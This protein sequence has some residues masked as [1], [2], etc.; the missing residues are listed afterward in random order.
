MSETKSKFNAVVFPGQGA[1]KLGMAKDFIE[2]YPVAAKVFETANEVLP[3]DIYEVCH[4]NADMLNQTNY[5]QPAILVAEMAMYESLKSEYGLNPKAYAG[6][7]LGEYSALTA[8][9]VISFETAL[10]MVTKRGELMN[11]AASDG[12]MT[13]IIMDEI[14]YAEVTRIAN[15]H[16][17]DVAND[18]SQQQVV[19]SGLESDM[20]NAITAL[21][22]HYNDVAFRAVPLTVSSA[23]HSRWMQSVEQVY[24]EYLQPFK[25]DMNVTNLPQ[26]ASNFL[27][28]FY[29][30]DKEQLVTAL[31]KQISGSVKW[32]SNMALLQSM[33]ILEL[34]PNRPLRGFFKTI[35]VDITSVIN[36]KSAAKAFS[37]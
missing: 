15:Q 27:G 23:F 28:G 14:P 18:N 31:A 8:A 29:P 6:H 35:G 30:A 2:Q 4:E 21:T 13:A 25:A 3:F 32:R 9:G 16:Q 7:S 34:G 20:T 22:H 19:L 1:Q 5:T 37:A 24:M 12:T 36:V 33:Q 10:Q 26:V 17:V 11:Q